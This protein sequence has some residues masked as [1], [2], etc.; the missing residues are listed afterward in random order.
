MTSALI[1]PLK[2]ANETALRCKKCGEWIALLENLNV[3]VTGNAAAYN[4]TFILS[5][6]FD[7]YHTPC[8]LKAAKGARK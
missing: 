5:P 7:I 4:G 3:V 6:A 1:S 2:I 8:F